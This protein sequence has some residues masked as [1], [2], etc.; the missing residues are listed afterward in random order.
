ML[1]QV[2]HG[3]A[4]E[5]VMR[6]RDLQWKGMSMWPPEWG[7]S[8]EGAGEEG[9]LKNVQLRYDQTPQCLSVVASQLGD[10]RNGIIILENPAHLE[11]LCSKLKENIGRPLSE[12]GNLQ[13]D[14][15]L[16]L[17]KKGPKLVRPQITQGSY[18]AVFSPV[19]IKR[20]S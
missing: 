15:G 6:I 18:S 12:I 13:I 5:S 9:V 2:G 1:D 7:I 3:I 20:K 14:F 4:R 8:D 16:L 11:I 10:H 17:P 19:A